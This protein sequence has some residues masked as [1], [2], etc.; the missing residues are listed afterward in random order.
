VLTESGPADPNEIVDMTF[1]FAAVR[2]RREDSPRVEELGRTPITERC[3]FARDEFVRTQGRARGG[4][5]HYYGSGDLV[6]AESHLVSCLS[7]NDTTRVGHAIPIR[8]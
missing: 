6:R 8:A 1:S 3:H 5:N 2:K 4:V 7:R